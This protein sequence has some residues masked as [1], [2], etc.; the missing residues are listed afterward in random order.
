MAFSLKEQF[1]VVQTTEGMLVVDAKTGNTLRTL[2][3]ISFYS[4]FTFISDDNCVISRSDFT[5]QLLN[6]KSGELLSEIDVESK[7]TCLAACPFNR[8][9]VIGLPNS[10]ANFKVIR[11]YLPQSEDNGNDKR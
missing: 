9:L 6:V 11:V 1:L 4:H 7:V 3:S 10:T 8:V 5:V 2:C